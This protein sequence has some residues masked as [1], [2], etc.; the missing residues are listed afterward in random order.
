MEKIVWW[1]WSEET[2]AYV[3]V[4]GILVISWDLFFGSKISAFTM[5]AY[6]IYT[7]TAASSVPSTAFVDKIGDPH[8]SSSI[9][10][11]VP[12]PLFLF[13]SL[14]GEAVLPVS[15]HPAAAVVFAATGAAS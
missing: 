12:P 2:D 15:V 7:C 4:V 13:L 11:I 8:N 10:A 14:L 1:F 6:C 5:I 3:V 9:S